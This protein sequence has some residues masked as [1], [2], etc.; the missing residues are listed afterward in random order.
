MYYNYNFNYNLQHYILANR[1]KQNKIFKIQ[2]LYFNMS[3]GSFPFSIWNGDTNI[4]ISN[5]KFLLYND[6][7]N[8]L[9]KNNLPI[10][11]DCSN[12]FITKD[13]IN[14][15][16]QNLILEKGK[17][18]GNFIELSDLGLLEYIQNTYSNYDFI[19]SKKAHLINS[20]DINIINTI[21]EQNIFYLIGLPDN[22]KTNIS[23]LKQIKNKEKIEIT[24]GN[25][26]KVSCNNLNICPQ[27]EDKYIYNYSEKTIY[28]N[29]CQKL[30]DY[31]NENELINEIQ[32][33]SD[34]GFNH[35]K[36]DTPPLNKIQDFNLYLIMN[37]LNKEYQLTYINKGNNDE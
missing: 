30:N 1:K 18:M 7:D 29:S 22:F 33:F 9:S 19:F 37:L 13:I 11:F 2:N 23:L 27:Y 28:N 31:T 12:I 15:G 17:D 16:Y 36:I 10:R 24:I 34:L 3:Y 21:I 8:F 4:N 5:Q 14:N 35:F 20:F 26:C 6:L 32:F 25:K